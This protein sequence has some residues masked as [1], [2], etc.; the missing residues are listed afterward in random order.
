MRK[1]KFRELNNFPY[2]P[3]LQNILTEFGQNLNKSLLT[4]MVLL[5]VY[6]FL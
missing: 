4:S 6:L 2:T 5:Y 1:L 3:Q